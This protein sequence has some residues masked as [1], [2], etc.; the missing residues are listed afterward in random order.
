MSDFASQFNRDKEEAAKQKSEWFNFPAGTT[1]V[2]VLVEPV[3]MFEKYDNQIKKYITCWHE[4]GFTGS[5]KYL[6]RLWIFETDK[7]GK[8][9]SRLV[10]CKLPY[11]VMEQIVKYMVDEDYK[12]SSFPMP[13]NIK[14]EKTGEKLDTEYTVIPS[15]QHTDVP[16]EALVALEGQ[17]P[18]QEVHASLQERAKKE[19]GGM[20]EKAKE[21]DTIEYPEPD[22]G[23]IPDPKDI[24]F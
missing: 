18:L 20:Q 7:D 8:D 14:V 24:P 3:K 5:M 15:P 13:Y 21:E 2:R 1:K 17:K 23:D 10:I 6:A 22:G 19:F 4:C 16:P 11:S 12:F 9:T